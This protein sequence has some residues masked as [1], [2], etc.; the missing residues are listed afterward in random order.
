M[1]KR[2]VLF[3]MN[4][5]MKWLW[6]RSAQALCSQAGAMLVPSPAP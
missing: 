3:M 2:L 6:A 5:L 4:V 1:S